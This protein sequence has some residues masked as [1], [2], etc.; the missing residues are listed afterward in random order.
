MKPATRERLHTAL[1]KLPPDPDGTY[2]DPGRDA[3]SVKRGSFPPLWVILQLPSESF[4]DAFDELQTGEAVS[5]VTMNRW[6]VSGPV[7]LRKSHVIA[8]RPDEDRIP[9]PFEIPPPPHRSLFK[10]IRWAI[11]TRILDVTDEEIRDLTDMLTRA[12]TKAELERRHGG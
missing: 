2:I 3:F 11:R 6:F 10:Q 5:M 8:T 9:D 12:I 4:L 1:R 7:V